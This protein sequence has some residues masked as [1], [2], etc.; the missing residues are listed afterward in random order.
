MI[1]K[2]IGE[3]CEI[4]SGYAFDSK[5]FTD[6]PLDTPLIRI[7]DVVRGY[8]ETYTKEDYDKKYI[9][10]KGDL[11]I[12]MD[13][14][15]N[16]A[17]WQSND[18]LLNQRVCKIWCS[19]NDVIDK[20]LFYFLTKTL[21]KIEQKTSYVTVK[22]LSVKTINEI[23][24]LLP[25]L[26]TQKQIAKTLD[27]VSELLAMRK[28]QLTELDNLIN[29]IF[30]DMFGDPL[31]NEKGWEAKKLGELSTLVSGGTPSRKHQEYFDG[32]I[33]WITTV[34]LGKTFIDERDAVEFINEKAILNS[35]TKLIKENSLLF[36]VR[37]GVGKISINRVAMCTNQ[38][39]VS[40]VDVN[41]EV[42]NQV[43][44]LNTIRA[45]A[46]YFDRQKRGATIQ[47]IKSETLKSINIPIPP[48]DLQIK[49]S[50]IVTKIEDQKALVQ[51]AIDETQYLFDS[52][53]SMYFD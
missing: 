20:Y 32:T 50:L 14:E 4:I 51:K 24:V 10:K 13:G 52:L 41:Q 53:M 48:M 36:G 38:D 43:Y 1:K 49:F 45:F 9:V 37:V 8:T 35:S 18:A 44:L 15:F 22:H 29:S 2:K 27:T 30:Y 39:I 6:N 21:K 7:R 16:I 47:G 11:L 46:D 40:I 34:S 26:E 3:I 23:E 31:T 25:H 5:L 19:S 42:L 28:Q 33:P 17:P 12:G